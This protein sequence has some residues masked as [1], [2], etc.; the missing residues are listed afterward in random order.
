M[1]VD[2]HLAELVKMGRGYCV[3][4]VIREHESSAEMI[5]FYTTDPTWKATVLHNS[6]EYLLNVLDEVMVQC[7]KGGGMGETD[8]GVDMWHGRNKGAEENS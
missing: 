2:E 1:N 5:P 4:V 6:I 3:E 8:S 7:S